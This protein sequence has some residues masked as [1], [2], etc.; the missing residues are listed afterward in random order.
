MQDV[1]TFRSG[2]LD[3]GYW[4]VATGYWKMPRWSAGSGR[5]SP[6]YWIVT[7]Y[8]VATIQ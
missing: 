7:R 4:I 5:D 3:T 1:V 8:P 2:L 6:D